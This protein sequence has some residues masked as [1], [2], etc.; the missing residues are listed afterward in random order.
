MKSEY[1]SIMKSCL[2]ISNANTEVIKSIGETVQIINENTKEQ[3][4]RI[5][6]KFTFSC[7]VM[8]FI[9]E[10]I[11]LDGIISNP[12]KKTLKNYVEKYKIN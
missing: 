5:D 1:N 7:A 3:F 12:I 6:E 4:Q 9:L 2:K 8:L 11:D 10:G